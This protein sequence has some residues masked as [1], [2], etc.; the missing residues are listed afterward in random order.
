MDS[1]STPTTGEFADAS[2]HWD[3]DRLYA[4]LAKA[5]KS[6]APYKKKELTDAEKERL[7]GLLCGC[8]PTEIARKLHL[9]LG[10][11][12]VALSDVY[13]YTEELTQR[14]PHTIRNW[15][16]IVEWLEAAGY[17]KQP[18]PLFL[19]PKQNWESS[20]DVSNFYGRTEELNR[21]KQWIVQ[22]RCRVVTVLGMGGIGKTA[23]SVMLAKEL[24]EEFEYVIWQ[25]LRYV[26]PLP[27]ILNRLLSF[28]GNPAAS[29]FPTPF[30]AIS[31]LIECLQYYRCLL[32]LDGLEAMLQPG[33]LAGRYLPE[34]QAYRELIKRLGEEDHNSCLCITSQEKT[35]EIAA[36]T[37]PLLPVRCFPLTGLDKVAAQAIL[38]DKGLPE[39]KN[40]QQLI[41]LYRGNPLALKIVA[42]T[43]QEVFG[44]SIDEFLRGSSV[45]V[46]DFAEILSQQFRRL[47]PIEKQILYALALEHHPVTVFQLRDSLHNWN[48]PSQL[49]EAWESLRRRSLLENTTEGFTLQPVVMKY[50]T[51]QLI[52]QICNEALVASRTQKLENTSLLHHQLLLQFRSGCQDDDKVFN[53]RTILLRVENELRIFLQDTNPENLEEQLRELLAVIPSPQLNDEV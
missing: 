32:V 15:R 17:K 37:G 8:S 13:R 50:V 7:R 45:F 1:T 29:Y 41:D 51:E 36:L 33:E 19:S 42:T 52:E 48:S 10:G 53:Y 40:T 16:E 47:S 18:S 23:V 44:G 49:T 5:K 20:P 34:H 6:I 39:Q 26:P 11:L 14:S 46:G 12:Q 35:P 3:L 25:S 9:S 24:A 22:D 4:D 30:E 2:H 38:K 27:K 31:K 28:L 43:I 21:L